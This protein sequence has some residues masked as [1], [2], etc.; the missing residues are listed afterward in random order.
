MP[1]KIKITRAE[2]LSAAVELVR[3]QG[4]QALNA[5]SIAKALHCSTQPIFSNF[6]SMEHLR[7]GVMEEAERRYQCYLQSDM[8]SGCFPPYKA[9]G[10][11]Y[12]RFAREEREL[13]KLLFM[14]D[15][16][17]QVIAEDRAAIRPLLQII[18]K[19]LGISEDEAYLFHLEMWLYVHG[20]ATMIATA[21]LNWDEALVSK[22]LTDAYT[23]MKTRFEEDKTHAVHSNP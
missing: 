11:A 13:F 1:P 14:R 20:I 21:F 22:F 18:E 7:Q 5:R 16:S 4:S 3:E 17:E 12:I 10:M 9:S 2:I 6:V 19:N 8:A 23:G 15:R